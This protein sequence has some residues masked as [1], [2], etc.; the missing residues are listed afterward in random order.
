MGNSNQTADQVAASAVLGQILALRQGSEYQAAERV[1]RQIGAQTM[2]LYPDSSTEN[3]QIRLMINTWETIAGLASTVGLPW[4]GFYKQNPV[5]FMWTELQPAV[6]E[7]RKQSSSLYASAFQRLNNS[8]QTWLKR[9]PR[10][11]QSGAKQGIN[12]SFG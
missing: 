3:G 1:R 5:G 12:A 9:Q 11:Y 6:K 7:I 4:D 2:A 10:K 8:Y